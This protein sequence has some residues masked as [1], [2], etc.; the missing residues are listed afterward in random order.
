MPHSVDTISVCPLADEAVEAAGPGALLGALRVGQ[1]APAF[2]EKN[3]VS[4]PTRI[5]E[6]SAEH[7]IESKPYWAPNVPREAHVLPEFVEPK[8]APVSLAGN[9]TP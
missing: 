7:E 8:T 5:M 1:E 4:P 3:E 2:V 6:P 9:E